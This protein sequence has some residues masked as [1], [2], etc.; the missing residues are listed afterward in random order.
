MKFR[1]ELDIVACLALP[2]LAERYSR[3]DSA[4]NTAGNPRA[5]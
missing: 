1:F 4:D 2:R 5:E 3:R